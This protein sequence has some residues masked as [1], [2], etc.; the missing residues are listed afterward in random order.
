MQALREIGGHF[1]AE[2]LEPYRNAMLALGA[3]VLTLDRLVDLI[4]NGTSTLKAGVSRVELQRL[5]DFYT[6]LWSVLGDL[7]PEPG[8]QGQAASATIDPVM[9]AT[10]VPG[11]AG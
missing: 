8:S 11:L 3:Q 7:L 6:P 1:P 2:D 5:K 10:G 9:S 4:G